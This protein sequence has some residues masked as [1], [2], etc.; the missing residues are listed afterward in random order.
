M[1]QLLLIT[2]ALVTLN[3][4]AQLRAPE[5]EHFIVNIHGDLA[6]TRPGDDTQNTL[7]LHIALEAGIASSLSNCFG[8]EVK[9]VYETFPG[10]LGGYQSYGGAM[11]IKMVSG[12]YEEHNYY[13]GFRA[14]KVYRTGPRM[15][16]TYRWNPGIEA[17]YNYDINDWLYSGLRFNYD[18]A[19]D[20][21]IFNEPVSTRWGLALTVGFKLFEL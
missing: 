5:Q 13:I 19:Y 16:K 4:N 1:K 18:T 17:Q 12:Y 8:V 15:G 2:A 7:G 14:N 10:L 3:L 20:L 9:A 21:E 11:G 6:D